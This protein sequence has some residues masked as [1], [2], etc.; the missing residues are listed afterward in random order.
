MASQMSD[1]FRLYH[2][3]VK[4]MRQAQKDYFKTRSKEALNRSVQLE[5]TVDNNI[6]Q[7]EKHI[8]QLENEKTPS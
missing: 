4:Q 1:R 3:A 2:E 5:K 7:I 8:K 6:E